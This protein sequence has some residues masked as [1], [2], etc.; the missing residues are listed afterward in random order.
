M[1]AH[2]SPPSPAGR[3]LRCPDCHAPL[4]ARPRAC[5][6]CELLLVGDTAQRLWDIDTE[7]ALLDGR[8]RSL[9]GERA[10]VV[11]RL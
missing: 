3:R 2:G 6:R 5:P 7:L 4:P 10:S 9:R 8:R 11:E 1:N